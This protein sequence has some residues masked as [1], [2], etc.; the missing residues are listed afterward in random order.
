[1]KSSKLEIQIKMDKCAVE[2]KLQTLT[3]GL[4]EG[5]QPLLSVMAFGI[6]IGLTCRTFNTL[7]ISFILFFT[8]SSKNHSKTLFRPQGLWV[9]SK[10]LI[11]QQYEDSLQRPHLILPC[12]Q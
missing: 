9:D 5:L 6:M 2:Q 7:D 1:M 10:S 8:V 4:S 12:T 3:G 11:K